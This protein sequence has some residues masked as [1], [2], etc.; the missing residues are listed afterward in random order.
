MSIGS[1][2][3]LAPALNAQVLP[4]VKTVA[5]AG[6]A[7]ESVSARQRAASLQGQIRAARE[8][9]NDWVTCV[10]ATTPKGQAEIR[11]LSA[12]ISAAQSQINHLQPTGAPAGAG[13]DTWA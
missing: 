5:A 13:L 8:Q 6:N 11:S 12:Q 1:I 7:L 9:L 4:R 2:G 3:A 10:S